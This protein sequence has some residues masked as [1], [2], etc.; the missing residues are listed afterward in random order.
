MY[1]LKW[2]KYLDALCVYFWATT[3]VSMSLMTFSVYIML[4]NPLTAATVSCLLC[5]IVCAKYIIIYLNILYKTKVFVIYWGRVEYFFLILKQSF[6]NKITKT[7]SVNFNDMKR[8]SVFNIWMSYTATGYRVLRKRS[9]ATS[10]L[11][12]WPKL[13]STLLAFFTSF[14]LV[15]FLHLSVSFT[16]SC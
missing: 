1:Y 16:S 10:I 2:R 14:W 15:Y 7:M 5:V 12:S 9:K 8:T 11:F 6:K 3:P 13:R 4:G